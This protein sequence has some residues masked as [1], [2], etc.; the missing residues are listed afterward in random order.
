[1]IDN[2]AGAG[3]GRASR[4]VAST[5]IPTG[6]SLPDSSTMDASAHASA[7]HVEAGSE[8]DVQHGK[9]SWS[10]AVRCRVTGVRPAP[11]LLWSLFSAL[12]FSVVLFSVMSLAVVLVDK[13]GVL[14]TINSLMGEA[15]QLDAGKLIMLSALGSIVVGLAAAAFKFAKLMLLNAASLL[16]G[17]LEVTLEPVEDARGGGR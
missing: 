4:V 10:D 8:A 9:T 6:D 5:P 2:T 1:M 11:A 14:A 17:P 7:V 3:V 15:M 13:A 16:V 12:V